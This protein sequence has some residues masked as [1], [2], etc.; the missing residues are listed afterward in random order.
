M[1][2]EAVQEVCNTEAMVASAHTNSTYTT[3][4]A[5]K[6]LS[7]LPPTSLPTTESNKAK[8]YLDWM[9]EVALKELYHNC[10]VTSIKEIKSRMD[11][12]IYPKV[13][14]DMQDFLSK[15]V[16]YA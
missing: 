1:W 9:R 5:L 3:L 11:H 10:T 6:T 2:A 16:S 8:E 12:E 14:K 13:Y 4:E 15:Y 7:S